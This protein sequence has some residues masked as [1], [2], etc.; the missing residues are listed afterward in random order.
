[1]KIEVKPAGIIVIVWATITLFSDLTVLYSE[2]TL[3][4]KAV[5][6]IALLYMATLEYGNSKN[7]ILPTP[8][9]GVTEN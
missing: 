5:A 9:A 8:E 4:I 2:W 1:M 7:Q 6:L 3:A